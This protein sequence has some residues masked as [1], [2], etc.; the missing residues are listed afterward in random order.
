LSWSPE[1]YE[2]FKT[3]RSQPFYDLVSIVDPRQHSAH[4]ST[5]DAAPASQ[6]VYFTSN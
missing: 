2:K 3:E 5:S 6:L 1:Q 4:P